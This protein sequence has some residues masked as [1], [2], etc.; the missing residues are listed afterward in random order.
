MLPVN[1]R[2]FYFKNVASRLP[3]GAHGALHRLSL[4]RSEI[5][6]EALRKTILEYYDALPTQERTPDQEE[7]LSFLRTNRFNLV[8]YDWCQAYLSMPVKVYR[9]RGKKLNY[10]VLDDRKIYFRRYTDKGIV[11]RAVRELSYEQDSR[12]PHRYVTDENRILGTL[13]IPP[14]RSGHFVKPGDIVADVGAADGIFSLSIVDVASHI[15]LFECD[16]DWIPALEE[17]FRDYSG[18]ITLV[19]K[20]VSDSEDENSITLDSYFK[21]KP[22]LSF[23]KADVE[24]AEPKMLRGA[25][26]LLKTGRIQR[27]SIC[28]YHDVSHPVAFQ[29]LFRD[30]G[31]ETKLTDGLML[32]RQKPYMVKG[33]LQA[34]R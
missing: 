12:S 31:Y 23:L 27:A 2:A 7:A 4:A 24:G 6:R 28:V 22:G 19:K 9:D 11:Q 18:K 14:A 33:V 30:A 15:Y 13:A 5:R 32:N 21:D 29:Q 26:T 16:P 20:F 34:A 3:A 25:E 8:P 17:T 10:A 1:I